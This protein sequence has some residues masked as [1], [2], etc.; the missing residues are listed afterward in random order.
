VIAESDLQD[1][2]HAEPRISTFFGIKID[3]SNE[4]EN[5]YRSTRVKC[6]GSSNVIDESDLQ[7][8]K[9]FES[10]ISKVE[11]ITID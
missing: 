1:E 4:C 5:A 9:Q 6:E 2:K 7:L 3:R 11:G 10:I 8:K